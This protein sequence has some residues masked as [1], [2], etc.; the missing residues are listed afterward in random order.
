MNSL[1]T[2]DETVFTK[3]LIQLTD[4]TKIKAVMGMANCYSEFHVFDLFCAVNMVVLFILCCS[5]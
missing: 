2:Q 4:N 3:H 1:L 5:L